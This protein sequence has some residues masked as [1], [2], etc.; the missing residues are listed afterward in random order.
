RKRDYL[1]G[2]LGAALVASL[3][4]YVVIALGIFVAQF[5]PWIDQARL[6]PV[7]LAPYLWTFAVFVIPNLLFTGALLA[8]LAVVTRSILWVYIGVIGFFVLYFVS[9]VLLSDLDNIWIATLAEP[10]GIRALSR[11]IR[12]WSAEERNTGLP[13]IGGYIL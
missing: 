12:Y 5:M 8:L 4:V 6:G 9:G 7:S 3:M 1:A 10:L 13:A 2:R 11:T